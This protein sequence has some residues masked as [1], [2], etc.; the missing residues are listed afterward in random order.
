MLEEYSV[1]SD[2][3][4]VAL[5]HHMTSDVTRIVSANQMT[6]VTN[7]ANSPMSLPGGAVAANP[8]Q[9]TLVTHDVKMLKVSID[10]VSLPSMDLVN[11]IGTLLL[12]ETDNIDKVSVMMAYGGLGYVSNKIKDDTGLLEA[13]LGD[14]EEVARYDP[15]VSPHAAD[16]LLEDAVTEGWDPSTGAE[17]GRFFLDGLESLYGTRPVTTWEAIY[18]R[19]IE[20][21]V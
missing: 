1:S 4:G 5:F 8:M 12:D 14:Y 15:N 7:F 16:E 11:R 10:A 18:P 3:L 9:L 6:L 13:L 21:E 2:M 20:D 17:A 19:P